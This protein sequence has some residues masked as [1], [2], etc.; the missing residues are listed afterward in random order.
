MSSEYKARIDERE[1]WL[2]SV[3]EEP[4]SGATRP[5]LL[6]TAALLQGIVNRIEVPEEG[7]RRSLQRLRA[8][9]ASREEERPG[10]TARGAG[11]SHTLSGVLG[12]VFRLG[13][14]K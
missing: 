2:A 11:W 5:Q 6:A 8:V 1:S 7:R 10:E 3:P 4:D 12:V 14:K 13:R 9:W